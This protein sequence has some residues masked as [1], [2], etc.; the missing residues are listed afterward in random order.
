MMDLQKLSKRK[1]IY[2]IYVSSDKTVHC[3]RYPIIY[4]NSEVVYYK[5]GR[6]KSTLDCMNPSYINEKF[7]GVESITLHCRDYYNQYFWEVCDF[8]S[9]KI[10]EVVFAKRNENALSRAKME[11]RRAEIAYS[12]KKKEY[13]KLLKIN[14]GRQDKE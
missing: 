6:K 12:S 4:L 13:E 8:D 3:E 2:R 1:Y 11:L 5:D 9:K 7:L 10:T 14:Q